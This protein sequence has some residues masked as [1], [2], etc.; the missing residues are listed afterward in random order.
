MP[1][2]GLSMRKVREVLRLHFDAGLSARKIALSCNIARSTVGEYIG[3]AVDSGL[4]WPLPEDMD[5]TKLRA[6]L[7]KAP[8]Y[9][10]N[11]PDM[12]YLHTEMRKK[13][14]TLQLLW[15]EYKE[16]H[17]EGYQ[18][19]QFCEYYRQGRRKL[20]LVLRQEHRAGEKMF[21][22]WAGPTVPIVDPR[23]GE[24]ARAS[25]F[26]AVLGASNY[27][28]VEATLDKTLPNWIVANIHA[29]EA[30]GGAPEI[31][32][33]D[34]HK[35]GVKSP[36]RY[37]PDL[38]R[39]YLDLA[40]HYGTAV[41]PTRVRKPKDNAKAE[42][43]VQVVERWVLAAIRNRTF[44]NLEEL[45]TAIRQL[46]EQLNNKPFKKLPTSRRE[47]FEKLDQPALKPL[48]S[49]RYSFVDWKT[50][51]VGIDYHIE[52]SRHFYSVPYQLT[53]EQVDVRLGPQVLEVLY[54]NRRV[55]SHVRSYVPGG[56]TTN[57]EHRPKAHQKH[58]E[59]TPSRIVR[60][61]S[62]TGPAT[63]EM[64]ETIMASRP[65]PEQGYRSCLGIIRLADRYSPKRLEA[66]CKRSL[67][68]KSYS[69]KS[70]KSI[71]KTGLDQ[72]P[73]K[74]EISE[75]GPTHRN[76]RGPEYYH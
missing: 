20:G 2:K 45:N 22:D 65:H 53:G 33:V 76:I 44:F 18:Y 16:A 54:K 71:L 27:T 17:P 73:L 24:I 36:C 74:E 32:V 13:G 26:V 60:W 52:V 37:E 4:E 47:L 15:Q 11:L 5:D 3:R 67:A 1:R 55:A 25:I 59:W 38:N 6:A 39:T 23:T 43:G 42:V 63:A 10:I 31:V 64:V 46:T 62:N 12:T 40:N 49:E 70:V 28:Y 34:N 41:I 50:A 19:T 9:R 30:F 21:V 61:A 48:P 14:V 68:I 51:R 8:N 57:P 56:A 75:P 72:V 58:L 35:A 66:A 7:F 69:Y 29:F